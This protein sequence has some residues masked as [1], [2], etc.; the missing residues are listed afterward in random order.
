MNNLVDSTYTEIPNVLYRK[1]NFSREKGYH[2][3]NT[4]HPTQMSF[5]IW[6]QYSWLISAYC[7]LFLEVLVDIKFLTGIL[8]G[9]SIWLNKL[10]RSCLNF[11]NR[12]A[13]SSWALGCL[14]VFILHKWVILTADQRYFE[15]FYFCIWSQKQNLVCLLLYSLVFMVFDFVGWIRRFCS[16]LLLITLPTKF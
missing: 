13:F 14:I 4:P 1:I 12:L 6:Y 9:L 11:K 2:Q 8:A 5:I 15:W 10:F 16:F 7:H 3:H